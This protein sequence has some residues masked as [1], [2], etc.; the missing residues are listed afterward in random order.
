[1]YKG[2]KCIRPCVEVGADKK[3]VKEESTSVHLRFLYFLFKHLTL[4]CT[5]DL[6]PVK[7]ERTSV[8]LRFFYTFSLAT[9]G[10]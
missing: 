8:N 7:E 5:E 1:M 3:P 6:K 4:L 9:F 10:T 2:V